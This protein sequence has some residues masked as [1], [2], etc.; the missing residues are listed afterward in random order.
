MFLLK[1]VIQIA[2]IDIVLADF[3]GIVPVQ[4]VQ[5]Y[6]YEIPV[7]LVVQGHNLVEDFLLAVEREAE[8]ADAASLAL[9]H[10]EVHHAVV[11]IACVE[12]LHSAAHSVQQIVVEIVH[13]QFLQRVTVHLNGLLA[14][15]VLGVEVREFRGHEVL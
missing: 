12:L 15:V 10:E 11:H 3:V 14:L 1:L 5:L 8:V 7:V 9:L 13:L 6:L 2:G 4:V